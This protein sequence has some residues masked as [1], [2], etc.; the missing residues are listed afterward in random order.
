MGR[1]HRKQSKH[2]GGAAPSCGMVM[3]QMM[4]MPQAAPSRESTSSDSEQDKAPALDPRS[5]EL[6]DGVPIPPQ[7]NE[8]PSQDPQLR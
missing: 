6:N 2:S 7:V 1:H 3:P 5:A 8:S 4:M